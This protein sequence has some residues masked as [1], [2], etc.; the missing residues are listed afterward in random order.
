MDSSQPPTIMDM[1]V[2]NPQPFVSNHGTLTN[3][4][5]PPSVAPVAMALPNTGARA[6]PPRH[7]LQLHGD[8]PSL[9]SRDGG[10]GEFAY[11]ADDLTVQAHVWLVLNK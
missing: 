5:P 2:P 9:E 1:V 3:H 6:L 10:A 8:G 4:L 11:G 7:P